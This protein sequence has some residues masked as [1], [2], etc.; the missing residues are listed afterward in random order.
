VTASIQRCGNC[1]AP[2][3]E[4]ADGRSIA[5]RHCGANARRA[6]D[7]AKLAAAL[8]R[9]AESIAEQ[10]AHLA[11]V[12][13]AI[14]P[15]RTSIEHAGMFSRKHV[16]AVTVTFEDTMFHL[17]HEASRVV[18][19]KRDL[20]RG[21]ALKTHALA[22]DEWLAELATALSRHA[23]TSEAAHAALARL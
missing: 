17:A 9:D 4:S 12:L 5:C 15:D 19:V 10:L 16:A 14:L 8:R 13:A 1:G 20:V 3:D 21:V 11:G 23:S 7:P 18:S 2:A 22:L 6:L